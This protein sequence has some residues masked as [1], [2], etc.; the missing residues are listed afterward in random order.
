MGIV[1]TAPKKIVWRAIEYFRQNKVID[2]KEEN[3]GC[4]SAKVS[5]SGK[6]KYDVFI[7]IKQPKK[8]ICTCP[9]AKKNDVICK[10]MVAVYFSVDPEAI[11]AFE[12]DERRYMED[13]DY[14]WQKDKERLKS[15]ARKMSKEELIDELAECWLQLETYRKRDI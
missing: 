13:K 12:E 7:N 9:F 15:F 1:E 10:H 6:S 2:I 14:R 3:D 8:S 5:G 11:T 4:Y